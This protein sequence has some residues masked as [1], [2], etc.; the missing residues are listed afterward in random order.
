MAKPTAPVVGKP[1]V[2]EVT[3]E[4]APRKSKAKHPL[5]GSAN[6]ELY[7]FNKVPADFD[8]EKHQSLKKKDFGSHEDAF[9]DYRALLC[10]VQAKKFRARAEESRTTGSKP[11]ED[12]KAIK[13]LQREAARLQELS[14]I[15]GAK[16]YNVAELIAKAKAAVEETAKTAVVETHAPAHHTAS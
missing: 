1:V 8:V 11:K 7:P 9:F 12:A 16:G 6:K 2:K 3:K 4:K 5:V 14:A 10:D 13:K 15:L